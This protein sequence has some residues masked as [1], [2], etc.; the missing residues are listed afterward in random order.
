[1]MNKCFLSRG[2]A[3][4]AV[5]ACT[6]TAVAC[7]DGSN[8][9]DA[10]AAPPANTPVPVGTTQSVG[11]YVAFLRGLAGASGDTQEPFDISGLT[12]PVDD[13]GEPGDIGQ[14]G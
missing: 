4:A 3:V 10:A 13:A 12:A 14:G 7:G 9:S 1:M 5:L 6:L 8:S 11:A 2:G